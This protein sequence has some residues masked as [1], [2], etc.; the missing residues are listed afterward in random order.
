[1]LDAFIIEEL[2]RREQERRREDRPVLRI[3]LDEECP[4]ETDENID[5]EEEDEDGS[6]IIIDY[7][8]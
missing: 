7:N 8:S 6:V 5:P 3:P 1:M 2:K 4:T